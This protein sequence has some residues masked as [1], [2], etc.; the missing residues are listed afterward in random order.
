[1][2]LITSFLIAQEN[3][4]TSK[5][6]QLHEELPTPNVYRTAS[7]A[8]GHEYYQ[9]K[10]DYVINV[11]LDEKKNMLSGNETIT[12]TNNSPDILNYLWVQLDQN[13]RAKNSH[14]QL[15]T[16]SS[17]KN[18][19]SFGSIKR[20]HD[21]MNFDGGFKLEELTDIY[22]RKLQYTVNET[23]MR[24]ELSKP[25]RK[26]QT[27]SFKIKYSYN[28]NDRMKI[29]GRS[30]YEYFEEDD[31]SIYT[32]AQ[33]FPRM[34]VYNEVE[35]WQNKQFLGRGEFSLPFGDY[36]VSITVP[37]D[38]I[39]AATG[40]LKNHSNVLDRK[41]IERLEKAKRNYT[42][43]VIIVNQDEAIENEQTK[44]ESKKTWIFEAENVR[45]FGWASSRKFIWDA[46]A[47]DISGKRVMAYSY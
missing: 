12:Y 28:I 6:K 33:F 42:E 22:G 30:G 26:G 16:T 17:M 31:N 2:V 38:H 37:A 23:M 7:G 39:V 29:G 9:Q 1:M 46:M 25:L 24:I 20:M 19:M 11:E 18:K 40:E 27:F 44:S 41:Q 43:P 14:S 34:A 32:I 21:K 5:F 4:N 15:T 8:P 3:L 13:V 10:A 35:G 36:K 47:V 45:D